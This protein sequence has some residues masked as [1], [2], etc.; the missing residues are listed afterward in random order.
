MHQEVSQLKIVWSKVLPEDLSSGCKELIEE[1]ELEEVSSILIPRCILDEIEVENIKS[2]Q[3]HGFSDASKVAY[4]ANV[5]I[6]VPSCNANFSSLLVSKTR[7]APL[8]RRNDF[9]SGIDGCLDTS[10]CNDS[11]SQG[12]KL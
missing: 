9:S 6:R 7:V 3:I 11:C 12:P 1:M 4:G 8:K 5:Y 2:I 10:K